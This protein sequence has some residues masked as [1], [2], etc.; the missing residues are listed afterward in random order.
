M[1]QFQITPMTTETARA[2]QAGGLDAYG[3]APERITSGGLGYPCRHCLEMIPEGAE[4]LVL[5][6]RPFPE[7]QPYAETGPVFLCAEECER[8]ADPDL[9]PIVRS[10]PGYLLK[11][12][13][14]DDRIVYGTGAIV[15]TDGIGEHANALL[16]RDDIAYVHARSATNNCFLFRIDRD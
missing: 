11:G 1:P 14:P 6:H 15:P 4:A 10:S 9:P 2:F 8:Y 12:Y 16:G 5:A 7:L 3:N 13:S